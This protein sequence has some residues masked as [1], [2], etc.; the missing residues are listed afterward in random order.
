[1]EF[2]VKLVG[3]KDLSGGIYRQIRRAIAHGRLR[4]GR[5]LARS[6]E[7]SRMTVTVAYDRLAGEGFV[8]SRVGAGTYVSEQA[9]ASTVSRKGLPAHGKVRPRAVW[10]SIPLP[11]V[12]DTP[13][14][15]DF[16]TGLPDASLFPHKR[17]RRLITS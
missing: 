10:T 3:R 11:P 8:T 9:A 1:M 6:L 13:A 12:F 7:V 5:E 14:P 16:R 17:W 15:F 4:P 2:F